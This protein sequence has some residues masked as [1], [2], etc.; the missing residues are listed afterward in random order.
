VR[1]GEKDAGP[2]DDE[3]GCPGIGRETSRLKKG[4]ETFATEDGASTKVILYGDVVLH[5]HLV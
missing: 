3:E 1:R 2:P 4:G 5:R